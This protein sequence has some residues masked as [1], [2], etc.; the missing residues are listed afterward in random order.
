VVNE[1]QL[2]NLTP[3]PSFPPSV[4]AT[5]QTILDKLAD[6]GSITRKEMG[7]AKVY[8]APPPSL[9]PS[10]LARETAALDAR[11]KALQEEKAKWGG[12]KGK[13]EGEVRGLS[14]GMDNETLK[15][16]LLA[17]KEE[18]EG[19]EKKLSAMRGTEGGKEGGRVMLD[20]TQV[21][22]LVKEM[23]K[24]RSLWVG[25]K[26]GAMEVVASVAEGAG[27]R[28]KDIVDVMGIETDEEAGV[29]LPP[30]ES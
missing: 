24:M 12:R 2:I 10:S 30:L 26:R 16:A 6:E 5:V 17:L 20:K 15:R 4:Q 13:A 21:A 27:K 1:I 29:S 11:V 14:G 7:K 8:V 19:R 3:L 23:A 18:N 22:G 28:V 25:R 9:D